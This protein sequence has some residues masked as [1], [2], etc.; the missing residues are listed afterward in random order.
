MSIESTGVYI[1]LAI[2]A[3]IGFWA[4]LTTR[5]KVNSLD[6]YFLGVGAFTKGRVFFTMFATTFSAF[7]VIGLPAM[8]YTHGVGAFWFMSIGIVFTPITLYIVGRK[9]I[10][11]AKENRG[12]Y[13]S[14]IGLLSAGYNSPSLTKF[15]SLITIV[16]LFPYLTLQIAGIGKFLVSISDGSLSYVVGTIICSSIVGIYIF[17]GGAK[18]DIITDNIQGKILVAGSIFV[19]ILIASKVMDSPDLIFENVKSK[20]LW[21]IEGPKGLFSYKFLFSYAV[22]FSLISIATPQVS[23]KIMGMDSPKDLRILYWLYPIV[24]VCV[25]GLAGVIGLYGASSVNVVS[26]DFVTGDVLRNL[27]SGS[28]AALY[29]GLFAIAVLFIAGIISAAVSTVD[30]LLLAISGIIRDTFQMK[31]SQSANKKLKVVGILALLLGLIFSSKPPLFIVSLAQIQLAGLTSLLP[32]LFGPM[33]GVSNKIGGW[34]A[35]VLGITPIVLSQFFG[36]KFFGFDVGLIGLVL[37]IVGLYAGNLF[38][39]RTK[40]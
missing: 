36:I 9:I 38:G 19:G 23:Q 34:T 11:L 6:D 33:L 40:T 18:A 24:G 7:T 13:S 4:V 15:L 2:T 29:Y 1:A 27:V 32:C 30:S 37:G 5:N 35:L 25:V 28:G 17:T 39:N 10:V 21:S 14:P 26:P 22:I 3:L 20:G 31:E 8:F 16:V 12:K